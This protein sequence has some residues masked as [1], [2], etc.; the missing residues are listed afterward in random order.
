MTFGQRLFYTFLKLILVVILRG[1]FRTRII[2]RH[3]VPRTGPLLLITN[4]P[5]F[6]DPPMIGMATPRPVS[7]MAMAELFQHPFWGRIAQAAGAFPIDRSRVDHAATREAIRRLRA[8]HCVAIFPEGG[9]RT[10]TN[11]ILGGQPTLKDGSETIAMLSGATILPV[12]LRDTHQPLHWRNWLCRPTMSITYGDPFCLYAPPHQNA[13][14]RRLAGAT[15]IREQIL[16]TVEL[17]E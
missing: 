3:R 10:G 13:A 14:R 6:V 5:S 9:I 12:I 7:F 2:G 15:I 1:I 11:S 17:T 8:G 16:K 4:H